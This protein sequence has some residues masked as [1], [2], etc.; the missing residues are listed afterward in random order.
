MAALPREFTNAGIAAGNQN[1][2]LPETTVCRSIEGDQYRISGLP[3]VLAGA[4][5]LNS[6]SAHAVSRCLRLPTGFERVR[7][8]R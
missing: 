7:Y 5:I 4:T 8:S 2:S 3:Y 1:L 6:K